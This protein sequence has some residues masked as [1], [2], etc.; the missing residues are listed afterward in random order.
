MALNAYTCSNVAGYSGPNGSGDVNECMSAPCKNG[1]TCLESNTAYTFQINWYICNNA[2]GYS[3]KNGETDINECASS[4]CK[5]AAGCADGANAYTCSCQTGYTGQ[6][7]QTLVD[8]CIE[9]P[10]FSPFVY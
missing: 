5:N 10:S 4:P 6:R 1:G 9:G 3:G 7:C 2:A 8:L